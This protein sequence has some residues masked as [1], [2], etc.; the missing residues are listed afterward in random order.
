MSASLSAEVVKS[1]IIAAKRFLLILIF[2]G[3]CLG[4]VE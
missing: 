2:T 3:L 1:L 4:S